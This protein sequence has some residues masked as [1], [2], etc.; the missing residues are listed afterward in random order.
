MLY[1]NGQ[2]IDP[3]LDIELRYREAE[4][5]KKPKK[6]YKQRRI[7]RRSVA[8]AI[9]YTLIT[10]GLYGIFWQFEIAKETNSLSENDKGFSPV[11]VVIFSILTLGIYGCYWS[12]QVGKK[13]DAFFKY[14]TNDE[15]DYRVLYLVLH[16]VNYIVPITRLI[17]YGF[18]Q[19]Q[20]NKMLFIADGKHPE[21]ILC[22]DS[23]FFNRPILSTIFLVFI[24]NSFTDVITSAYYDIFKGLPGNPKNYDSSLDIIDNVIKNSS[25]QIIYADT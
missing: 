13:H 23:H 14:E 22:R 3:Y 6:V 15:S 12:Y 17:S 7:Y 24:V 9:I 2:A 5:P 11:W 21:G 18:M 25:D 19:H 20:M 16:I 10:G 4:S 1:V 8:L